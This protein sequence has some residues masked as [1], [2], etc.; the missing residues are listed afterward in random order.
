MT[1]GGA[2]R[3]K[4][5][6]CFTTAFG[7]LQRCAK[8]G[9]GWNFDAFGFEETE[10]IDAHSVRHPNVKVVEPGNGLRE[11]NAGERAGKTLRQFLGKAKAN[12]SHVNA[13]SRSALLRRE[14]G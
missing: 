1:R 13:T 3:V 6:T 11:V 8:R 9:F 2:G 14:R 4:D 7:K 10:E 12:A 5:A